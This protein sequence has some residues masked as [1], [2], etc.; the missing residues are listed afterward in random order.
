MPTDT[1]GRCVNMKR[2]RESATVQFQ[3]E[4]V[5][6]FGSEQDH[7]LRPSPRVS[8]SRLIPA[9]SSLIL[10]QRVRG[11][12][13]P[14]EMQI[15]DLLAPARGI[16]TFIYDD[17]F[18][19]PKRSELL[20][21]DNIDSCPQMFKEAIFT[22]NY[23]PTSESH[24]DPLELHTAYLGDHL[25][26][27]M[28][29]GIV[30][31]SNGPGSMRDD[32]T[33]LVAIF[34]TGW[35]YAETAHNSLFPMLHTGEPLL[36]VNQ[37]SARV[38]YVSASFRDL[39]KGSEQD[40][41]DR[42]Y[43]EI[44]NYLTHLQS[45]HR[46]TI[47]RL[48]GDSLKL[49]ILRPEFIKLSE[50]KTDTPDIYR[51]FFIHKARNLLAAI[52][53][54]STYLVDVARDEKNSETEK[55][56][57]LIGQEA[58][59]LEHHIERLELLVRFSELPLESC[60]I[61]K[62]VV[63]SVERLADENDRRITADL[64]ALEGLAIEAPRGAVIS[65]MEAAIMASATPAK[66]CLTSLSAQTAAE[67]CAV[68]I[69]SVPRDLDVQLRFSSSWR[70]YATRVAELMNVETDFAL[71]DENESLTVTLRFPVTGNR[72]QYE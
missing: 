62:A 64:P 36:V 23:R 17:E 14:S 27:H 2:D 54:A 48:E 47:T 49:G 52:T 9:V 12:L 28:I 7:G 57:G 33:E 10:G 40:L 44:E 35:Q 4:K 68:T 30:A 45:N 20:A 5:N 50:R 67:T 32:I 3:V 69:E 19:Q 59:A 42:E 43:G 53:A 51:D 65:L 41:M 72:N 56:A 21:C 70:L 31:P 71:S 46:I 60:D 61:A 16:I 37:T 8:R 58:F 22:Q 34:R 63:E 26:K 29:L 1:I 66:N 25:D 24:Q 55:I 13:N 18:K 6:R 38:L 15:L 11:F 39:V